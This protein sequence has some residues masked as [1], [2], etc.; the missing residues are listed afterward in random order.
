LDRVY[1][2][3]KL[4]LTFYRLKKYEKNHR[5]TSD[6]NSVYIVLFTDIAESNVIKENLIP[7]KN[8]LNIEKLPKS[9]FVIEDDIM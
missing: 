2:N 6:I 9:N 3:R 7:E 5:L 4:S 8:I 1:Q